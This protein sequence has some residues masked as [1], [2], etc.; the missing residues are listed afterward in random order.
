M[1]MIQDIN[2]NSRIEIG[3]LST[4]LFLS[5]LT[6][7]DLLVYSPT[8]LSLINSSVKIR[9]IKINSRDVGIEKRSV[10][11]F[12]K[13][14]RFKRVVSLGNGKAT[15]IAKYIAS[16]ADVELISIPTALTTNV[17]FTNNACLIDGGDKRAFV[18]KVP[19]KVLIDFNLLDK[20][21]FKFHLYGL[22]DV[23]S[24]HTALFDWRLSGA[25]NNESIDVFL[26]NFAQFILN[27]LMINKNDILKKNHKSMR[28][29]AHLIMLSGYITNLAGCGRPESGSEHIVASFLE[30]QTETFHAISVTAGMLLM[31]ELQ[32]NQNDEI[33]SAL[34]DFGLMEELLDSKRVISELMAIIGKIKPRYDRYT[35]L[36]EKNITEKDLGRVLSLLKGEEQSERVLAFSNN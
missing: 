25:K 15:D 12:L 11:S 35:I 21:P 9:A 23:L 10:D 4:E 3:E 6:N 28:I 18:T 33:F 29:I 22:C 2:F 5:G 17:F 14:I 26:F 27:Q 8:S 7:N 1:T 19:D 30:R 36:N 24:I 34:N 16:N 31:M 32:D 20:T 13:N